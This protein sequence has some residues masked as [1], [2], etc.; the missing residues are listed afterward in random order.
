MSKYDD[1]DELVGVPPSC[2]KGDIICKYVITMVCFPAFFV[3]YKTGEF[4]EWWN[5]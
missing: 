2:V 4:L 3:Y 1:I 5:N